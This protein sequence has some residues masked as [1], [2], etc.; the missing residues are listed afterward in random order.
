MCRK[1][2]VHWTPCGQ[3]SKC[4]STCT[5]N[6]HWTGLAYQHMQMHIQPQEIQLQSQKNYSEIK[7]F[8]CDDV[9]VPQYVHYHHFGWQSQSNGTY[10]VSLQK[11]KWQWDNTVGRSSYIWFNLASL[12]SH[13]LDWICTEHFMDRQAQKFLFKAEHMT[14]QKLCSWI[15]LATDKWRREPPSGRS[16]RWHTVLQ[17]PE[18]YHFY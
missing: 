3:P 18:S 14:S 1:Q 17:G 15:L 2:S 8:L 12:E 13:V 16:S 6:C 4:V 11:R 5:A 7:A 10:S 9:L